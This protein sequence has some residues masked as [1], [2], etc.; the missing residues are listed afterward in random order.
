MI[1]NRRA[2]YSH[3]SPSAT[4]EL[5]ASA[6]SYLAALLFESQPRLLPPARRADG[7]TVLEGNRK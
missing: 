3:A 6:A 4:Y 2:D 5:I 1:G 7:T